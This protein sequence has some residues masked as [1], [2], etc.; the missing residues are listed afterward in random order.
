M[1]S[2]RIAIVGAGPAGLTA[3]L[4]ACRLGLEVTVFEQASDF[5]RIGGGIAIQDNGQRVLEAL[6]LLESFRP[7]MRHCPMAAL[8]LPGGKLL[9][10]V[11]LRKAS[12]LRHFPAVV[13]RYE[14][15]EY[16][17]AAAI[18]ERVDVQFGRRCT[19]L[20]LDGDSTKLRFADGSEHECDVVI[21]CDG[22]NSRTR[23]SAGLLARKTDIGRAYIRGVAEFRV[24]ESKIREIWGPDGRLFGIAPLPGDKAYFYC[25]VPLGQWQEI[26]R[27]GLEKWIETWN[28]Y[29]PDAI[30]ILRAV[31]DWDQVNYDELHEINLESWYKV[32]V[33]VVGDAA[34]AMTPYLGQ[35]ANCAMVDALVLMQLLARAVDAGNNLE[36]VGQTYESLRKAFVTR[37]QTMSRHHGNLITLSLTPARIVR[38]WLLPVVTKVDWLSRRGMLLASGYNPKEESYFRIP[39]G[40]V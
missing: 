7:I 33:F 30:S 36:E 34:H 31:P 10:A 23:E 27:G 11:D 16:L 4:A 6:G 28:G 32:P 12:F 1:T 8:E 26:V 5:R 37:T 24:D 3:A 38:N 39:S 18:S 13:L 2:P 40:R 21:A 19:G 35:C 15:Q 29:G 20:S 22:I 25:S 14:L 9:V 17:L